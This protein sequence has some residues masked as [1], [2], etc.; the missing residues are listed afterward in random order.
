MKQT[1]TPPPAFGVLP[2]RKGDEGESSTDFSLGGFAGGV[3]R[4]GEGVFDLGTISGWLR[5]KWRESSRPGPKPACDSG[6]E[7][8]CSAQS[9]TLERSDFGRN[10]T[11]PMM[12]ST[13]HGRSLAGFALAEAHG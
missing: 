9:P 5:I 8:L 3:P 2:H 6:E 7:V 12:S 4:R 13:F 11:K 1:D 10:F